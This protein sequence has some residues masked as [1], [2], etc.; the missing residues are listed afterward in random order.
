MAASTC[1]RVFRSFECRSEPDFSGAPKIGGAGRKPSHARFTGRLNSDSGTASFQGGLSSLIFR[2]PP[3]FVRQLSTKSR[4]NCSNI[5]VAQ[6]VAASWSNN[7]ASPS[8][9]AAAAAAA[10]APAAT[11][12]SVDPTTGDGVALVEQ[13]VDRNVNEGVNI[14][15][16]G[17]P[18]SR[19]SIFSSDRSLTIHA[20]NDNCVFSF[21]S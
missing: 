16:E 2:F 12:P 7:P 21:I 17:L 1:A 8:A 18:T 14:D 6:I 9:A 20:G 10:S 3:N 5:G 15:L 13:G 19:P 4:R 11:E